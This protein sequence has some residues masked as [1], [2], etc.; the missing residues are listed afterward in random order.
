MDPTNATAA[1]ELGEI[2]RRA[3]RLE[4]AQRLFEAAVAS[5]PDFDQARLGLGRVLLAAG[6]AEPA[7]L[8]LRKAAALDPESEVAYYQLARAYQTL[9]NVAGQQEALAKYQ[10]LR[11]RKQERT[12]AAVL[13]LQ[14]TK[15]ELEG[16]SDPPGRRAEEDNRSENYEEL[17]HASDE[18]RSRFLRVAFVA[19]GSR[20]GHGHA[21]SGGAGPRSARR[22]GPAA[23]QI[24]GSPELRASPRLVALDERQ[25]HRGG[26]AQGPRVDEARGHRGRPELRRGAATPRR[27]STS[28]WST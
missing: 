22:L 10:A 18:N 21:D 2:H 27:S 12:D 26:I 14:V 24:P 17:P 15:Q 5:Y 1:Y 19:S 9:G 16:K 4:E 23:G 13:P 6:K 3:G 20:R 8:Q 28:A 11:A 25:H 7:A